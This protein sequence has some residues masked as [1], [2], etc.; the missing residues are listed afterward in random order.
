MHSSQHRRWTPFVYPINE[1]VILS[2]LGSL[3]K[4][5]ERLEPGICIYRIG[6]ITLRR[7]FGSYTPG[8]TYLTTTVSQGKEDPATLRRRRFESIPEIL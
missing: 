7:E 2:L 5:T 8:R 4:F 3:N 6:V 1:P